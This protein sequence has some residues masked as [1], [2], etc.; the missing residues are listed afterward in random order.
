MQG[1]IRK[2]AA[3]ESGAVAGLY[4]VALIGLIAIGGVGFDYARMAG[5]D[6]E[7]QNAADQ[8]ALAAATQLDGEAQACSRGANAAIGLLKNVTLLS[9]VDP[10]QGGR[11]EVTIN[12]K[13]S[14]A[15]ADNACASI[16]TASG[17]NIQFYS[18]YQDRIANTA[19]GTDGEAN[20]VSI[21][22]DART[23]QYAFTPIV[24]AI[25]AT[26]SA[27][28][29]ASLGSSI[30]KVPPVFMCNPFEKDTVGA[31]FNANALKGFGLKL[32]SGAPDVPGNFGFLDTG[33]GSNTNSTPELA[34]ALGWDEIPYDCA[35]VDLVGLKPGQRDVVF[36]AFNTRFDINTNGANTCPSGGTCGAADN[37]RKDLIKKKPNNGSNACGVGGQGWTETPT[38]YRPTSATV[39]LTTN[40]PEIMGFPRDMC[41]AVSYDGSCSAASGLIGNALWDR[42]AYFKVNYGWNHSTWVSELGNPNV[43]RYAVYEWELADKDNRLKSQPVGAGDS[44]YSQPVCNGHAATGTPDRRKI[45]MAV[46]N[47]K[48]QA[49]KIAGNAKVEILKWVDVFLV[50]P[51]FNRGSG[52]AKRTTDD[53]VYVEVIEETR[54]AGAGGETEIRK[55]KPFLIE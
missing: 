52:N 19:A 36:N 12:S 23:A 1:V 53:Q 20:V 48:S 51:A 29:V 17:A 5:M 41:H 49:D 43:S 4:A 40:Y 21:Q 31:D 2:F 33:F 44:A 26:L 9:N 6:S 47:C 38:P 14:F 45:S 27:R 13:S 30:C 15:L 34:K 18:S 32:L 25:R 50:E 8:A 24:G 7:L 39:P 54:S 3:D 22:V 16:K 55:D 35:P 37:T 11:N 10:D 28:A 42:D 46:V